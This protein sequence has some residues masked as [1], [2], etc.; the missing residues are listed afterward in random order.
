MRRFLLLFPLIMSAADSDFA[1]AES[2]APCHA[3]I[4]QTQQASHHAHTL[5]SVAAVPQLTSGLP[6]LYLDRAT[7]SELR[8]ERT[9]DQIVLTARKAD[10]EHR[11]P[12]QWAFGSG[13]QGI[14]CVGNRDDGRPVE[15][16]LTWYRSLT[17]FDL[18]TGATRHTPA[19]VR[20]SLGREL[21]AEELDRCFG[22]HGGGSEPG[23]RCETCHGPGKPHIAAV[24]AG[25]ADRRILHP[26]KLDAFGQVQ[27]CGK[28]HG[29]PP[30]DTDL[31]G[32]RAIESNPNT[33][34][35]A[36]PRLVLSRCFNESE[37]G[38]KC[39]GCH[40]PH[41]DAG[42]SGAGY[43]RACA[44]CH[45][46]QA[47]ARAALCPVGKKNCASCHMPRERV[48]ANSEFTDH[49]IRVVR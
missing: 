11:L 15:A 6:V 7:G 42:R 44:S 43:D 47:R 46:R 19:N 37:A 14:T 45:N 41:E 21:S 17:A 32:L 23:V 22:C 29:T 25:G 16:R 38:L 40:E 20:E 26:G 39:S 18:T 3:A 36:S 48:M 12:L 49:W 24:K 8:L 9:G 13:A 35:F 28:C 31:A 34:R 5:R 10:E 4:A 27:L 1:G 2:C 30:E 33:V